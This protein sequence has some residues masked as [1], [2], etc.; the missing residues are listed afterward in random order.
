M[1]KIKLAL[2][3][4]TVVLI[5]AACSKDQK[6]VKQL[7]GEWKTTSEKVNGV[8]LPDSLSD[9]TGIY[10][11]EKCKVKKGPC[12]GTYTDAGKSMPFTYE[13]SEKGTKMTM[14]VFGIATT[15]DIVESSKTK[16]VHKYTEDGDTY[17]ITLEKQ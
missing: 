7:D 17:E 16:F 12:S 9:N 1:K 8:E 5:A 15:S 14:T 13:I 11:F 10:K 4:L 6:V 2:L 3:A